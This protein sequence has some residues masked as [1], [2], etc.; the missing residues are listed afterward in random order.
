MSLFVEGGGRRVRYKRHG[1]FNDS[2][3]HSLAAK[4]VKTSFVGFEGNKMTLGRLVKR[5]AVVNVPKKDYVEVSD[6]LDGENWKKNW[7]I[8]K[9]E[10]QGYWDDIFKEKIIFMPKQDWDVFVE[11]IN[12]KDGSEWAKEKF[13]EMDG[14][15]VGTLSYFRRINSRLEGEK[16]DRRVI[17]D[18]KVWL[19]VP[20]LSYKKYDDDRYVE[21][22]K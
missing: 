16:K 18:A 17:L 1:W 6:I 4:G 8:K 14:D 7:R 19:G 3:R 9:E 10:H 11:S 13:K 12:S 22:L 20:G 21:A 15:F 2:F 5:G